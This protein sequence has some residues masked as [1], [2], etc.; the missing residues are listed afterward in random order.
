MVKPTRHIVTPIKGLWNSKRRVWFQKND[1]Y[2]EEH[3]KS[4]KKQTKRD[5]ESHEN[6]NEFDDR[7]W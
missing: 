4:E 7:G 6:Q 5:I 2:E 3:N 1:D